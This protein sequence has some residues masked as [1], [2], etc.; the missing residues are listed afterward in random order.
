M[1]QISDV[2]TGREIP[3]FLEILLTLINIRVGLPLIRGDTS[4]IRF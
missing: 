1:S 2:T 3:E 4:T